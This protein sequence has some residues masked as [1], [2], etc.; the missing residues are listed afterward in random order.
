MQTLFQSVAKLKHE[1]SKTLHHFE[2]VIVSEQCL[3]PEHRH[4]GGCRE[5]PGYK[6]MYM[7]IYIYIYTIYIYIYPP[8]CLARVRV[9]GLRNDCS[10]LWV[11]LVLT[12]GPPPLLAAATEPRRINRGP[13]KVNIFF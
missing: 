12:K 3:I 9:M 2:V 8:P 11:C 5:A 4:G 13:Q 7:Y 6:N 1:F 10:T